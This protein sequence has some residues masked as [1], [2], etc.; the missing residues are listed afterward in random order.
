MVLLPDEAPNE[1]G[2]A[3]PSITLVIVSLGILVVQLNFDLVL[4]QVPHSIKFLEADSVRGRSLFPVA[5]RD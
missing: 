5:D 1:I 3:G 4:E 2:I